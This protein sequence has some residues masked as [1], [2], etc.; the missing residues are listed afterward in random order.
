MSDDVSRGNKKNIE[1]G[2]YVNKAKHGYNKDRN[3]N[4]VP[5]GTNFILMQRAFQLRIEGKTLE[6]NFEYYKINLQER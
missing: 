4:L 6:E 2:S 3:G 5:A 1:R